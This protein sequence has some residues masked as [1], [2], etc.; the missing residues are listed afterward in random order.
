MRLGC[1]MRCGCF[2]GLAN[3]PSSWPKPVI[4]SCVKLSISVPIKGFGQFSDGETWK[5]ISRPVGIKQLQ[6]RCKPLKFKCRFTL[7]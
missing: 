1:F 6:Q 7:A 2:E 5:V 3:V 4:N